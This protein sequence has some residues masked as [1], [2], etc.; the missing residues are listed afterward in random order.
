MAESWGDSRNRKEP[1]SPRT[2]CKPRFDTRRVC[3]ASPWLCSACTIETNSRKTWKWPPDGVRSTARLC[4]RFGYGKIRQANIP[5]ESRPQDDDSILENDVA[6]GGIRRGM[7][8]GRAVGQ[9]TSGRHHA[10]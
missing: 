9:F 7:C 1:A 4:D 8:A 6:A 5:A 2:I 3:P 10:V